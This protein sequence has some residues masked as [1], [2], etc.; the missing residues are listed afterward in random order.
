MDIPNR[1]MLT[2][3]ELTAIRNSDVKKRICDTEK[4]KVML[5]EEIWLNNVSDRLKLDIRRYNIDIKTGICMLIMPE[6]P[7][8]PEST[9][10]PTQAQ[11]VK[12][13]DEAND[14]FQA[15]HSVRK[16]PKGSTP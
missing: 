14:K 16:Q 12:A 1:V 9:K 11:N 7:P 3:G 4:Q 15:G 13:Q 8:K 10:E 6:N 2:N 5:Q